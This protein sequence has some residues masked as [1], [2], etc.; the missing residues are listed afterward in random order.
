MGQCLLPP[1]ARVE[2]SQLLWSK[3]T[4]RKLSELEERDHL[5]AVIRSL[6]CHRTYIDGL[7]DA[8]FDAD[9]W[10]RGAAAATGPLLGVDL[11]VAF[12]LVPA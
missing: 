4:K 11:A 9:T 7:G 10:L 12:E 3:R 6:E 8:D 1:W 5:A 2:N